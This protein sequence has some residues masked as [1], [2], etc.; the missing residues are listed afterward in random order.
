M[1]LQL[2][3]LKQTTI[4]VLLSILVVAFANYAHLVVVYLDI[5]YTKTHLNIAPLFS[6]NESGIL[7]RGI[8]I[9][10]FLPVGI[11]A[12]PSILYRGFMGEWMPYYIPI[13]WVV[14]LVIVV[15]KI[16]IV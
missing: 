8:L 3:I 16:I 6:T 2:P 11:T 10:T 1:K 13:T 12:I 9:L 4:Y 7:I 14:W 5:L 15:S